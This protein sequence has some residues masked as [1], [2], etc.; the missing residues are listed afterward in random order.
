VVARLERL[1]DNG[2]NREMSRAVQR[3][4]TSKFPTSARG[5]RHSDFVEFLVGFVDELN[6]LGAEGAA[7]L[8]EGQR[9]SRALSDLGYEGRILTKISMS[10]GRLESSL[11][12]VTSVII[13]TDMDREGRRLAAKYMTF[14]QTLRIGASLNQRRR[15]RRA[16]GGV[17][18]HIE[19]LSRFN[20]EVPDLRKM[21]E[22]M[23]V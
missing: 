18:L 13:L 20:P 12:G 1:E 15:L 2:D 6:A 7:V 19:N 21:T 5:K 14:L 17:F 16:S 3:R 9:D 10:R 4:A 22:K 8:V 23:R 11:R